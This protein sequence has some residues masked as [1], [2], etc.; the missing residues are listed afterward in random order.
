MY[1]METIGQRIKERRKALGLTQTDIH[2]VCGIGSGALSQI[3]NGLRT[4]SAVIFYELSQVLKC[5]MNW[6]FTGKSSNT[7]N[8]SLSE[9][10]DKLLRCFRQ[11]DNKEKEDVMDYIEYKIYK[12][13]SGISLHTDLLSSHSET[14]KKVV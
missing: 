10:E 4:P 2:K 11:L 7:N 3:E 1:S 13:G 6:L 12:K 8:Q 14:E 5:D 9:S